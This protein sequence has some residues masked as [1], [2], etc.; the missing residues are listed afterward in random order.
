[1]GREV[2]MVPANWRHPK[3]E[4]GGYLPLFDGAYL[5]DILREWEEGAAK[6]EEGLR[7]DFR[8]GWKPKAPDEEGMTYEEWSGEKPDAD[9]YM[10]AWPDAERT[11]LMMYETTSEGTPISPAFKTPEELA[12][13][14]ADNNASAFGDSTATYK[15]WLG[16]CKSGYAPSMVCDSRGLRSGVAASINALE[17]ALNT[18][19][20][21]E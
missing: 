17:F 4:N 3:S 16:T 20:S 5:A 8:G 13:W 19:G 2:R 6:R 14:L 10:P 12:R 11:H 9:D 7:D 18:K 1:M 21:P 15:Q